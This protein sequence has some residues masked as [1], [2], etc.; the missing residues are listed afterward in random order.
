MREERT[1]ILMW[2]P[3]IS[4]M[5]DNEWNDIVNH[6]P[7]YDLSWSVWEYDK[8]RA[9]DECFLVRIGKNGGIVLNGW[10]TQYPKIGQD[11]SGKGRTTFYCKIAPRFIMNAAI[12][13]IITTEELQKAI[14]TFDWCG[15]HSGRLL[16]KQEAEQL[17]KLWGEY[18]KTHTPFINKQ[19]KLLSLCIQKEAARRIVGFDKLVECFKRE[20]AE[21]YATDPDYL[22]YDGYFHDTANLDFHLD[23]DSS[24]FHLDYLLQD[25]ILPI[26]CKNLVKFNADLE[27]GL[28]YMDDFRLFTVGEKYLCLKANNVEV[29]C[30]EISFDDVKP[31]TKDYIP[32]TI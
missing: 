15:G 22:Y 9:G 17:H 25:G 1:F 32:A 12:D 16:T 29:I 3:E 31:Y 23:Y 5:K 26:T 4:N 11:W 6:F 18:R 7:F 8:A 24:T 21:T 13:P 30:E 10:F 19:E 14:P 20:W 2:N 28:A 27:K